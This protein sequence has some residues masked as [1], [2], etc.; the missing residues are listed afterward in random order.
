MWY[1][2]MTK[3]PALDSVKANGCR[4]WVEEDN[5]TDV[6]DIKV[7]HQ[8]LSIPTISQIKSLLFLLTLQDAAGNE[9]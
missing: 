9:C 8:N 3:A 6:K 7:H 1:A 2:A 4:Q 5:C